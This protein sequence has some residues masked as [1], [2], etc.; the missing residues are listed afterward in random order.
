M[1]DHL[2]LSVANFSRAREFYDL[3]L[4]PLGVSRLYQ[5]GSIVDAGRAGYGVSV[6]QFWI[7]GNSRIDGTLHLA[8]AAEGRHAVDEF[9][10]IALTAGA[11]DNGL[12]GYRPQYHPGYYAAYVIDPDGYNIEAVFHDSLVA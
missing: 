3:V 4:R 11:T 7:A 8:F 1:I 2:I 6:P 9:Y 12:P 5:T 10:R